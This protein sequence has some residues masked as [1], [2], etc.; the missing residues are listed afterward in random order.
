MVDALS[1]E[2]LEAFDAGYFV[3]YT[4][5]QQEFS[6]LEPEAVGA[7]QGEPAGGPPGLDDLAAMELHGGIALELPTRQ[8]EKLVRLG[9]VPGE[10]TMQP[11]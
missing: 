9:S 5:S 6:G 8:T 7:A 3:R 10:I 2:I 11:G 1:V 4:G